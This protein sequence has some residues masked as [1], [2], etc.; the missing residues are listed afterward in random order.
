MRRF[1]IT[2]SGMIGC[3]LGTSFAFSG[4]S[5]AQGSPQGTATG[6]VRASGTVMPEQV[7][8][9][10]P[11]VAGSIQRL[12]TDPQDSNR[13]LDWGTKVKRG[14]VLAYLDPAPYQALL[15]QARTDLQRAEAGL[16]LAVAKATQAE[17]EFQR[18]KKQAGDKADDLFDL[19]VRQAI[20]DVA[21]AAVLDWK[22]LPWHKRKQL[23]QR[24]ELNLSSCTIQV[25]YRWHRY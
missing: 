20:L 15:A 16:R 3:F 1:L 2:I 12:G 10:Y 4:G 19:A 25:S 17:R 23:L 5:Q 8:D 21:K 11:S 24:A 7:F 18:M 9:I 13:S 14:T 6:V 22:S